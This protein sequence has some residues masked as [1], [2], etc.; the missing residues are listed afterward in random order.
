MKLEPT[1]KPKSQETASLLDILLGSALVVVIIFFSTV[2]VLYL[3]SNLGPVSATVRGYIQQAGANIWFAAAGIV[4]A[5]VLIAAVAFLFILAV[6][7]LLR[8]TLP[9]AAMRLQSVFRTFSELINR[10]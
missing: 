5:F 6:I 9:V 7:W 10:F 2:I 3:L 8:H 1:G 4:A